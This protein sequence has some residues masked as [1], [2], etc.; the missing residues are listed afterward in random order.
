MRPCCPT[1]GTSAP[2]R[3]RGRQGLNRW[4]YPVG[5]DLRAGLFPKRFRV[6]PEAGSESQPHLI[7]S[8]SSSRVAPRE[9]LLVIEP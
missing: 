1:P 3:L 6:V 5:P 7:R 2:P 8:R 9:N 4:L